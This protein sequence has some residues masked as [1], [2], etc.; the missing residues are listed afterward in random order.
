VNHIDS[1]KKRSATELFSLAER[2]TAQGKPQKAEKIYRKVIALQLDLA[3]AHNNLGD[4]LLTSNRLLEAKLHFSR[5]I[6]LK[7]SI[8][9]FHNNLAN[10]LAA[11]GQYHDAIAAYRTALS[12]QPLADAHNGLGCALGHVGEIQE[13]QTHFSKALEIDPFYVAARMNLGLSL[14]GQGKVAEALE[15][16]VTLTHATSAPGFPV[17]LFGILLARVGCPEG[18]KECFEQYL[19]K[20]PGDKDG[21]A[22]LLAAVGGALPDRVSDQQIGQIY[23]NRAEHWDQGTAGP[24][25]YQGHKL[26]ALTMQALTSQATALDI[27]DA[28]CGTGLVG[29]LLREKARR[30]VGIDL[31]APMLEKARDKKTY[32]ELHRR[33]LVDYLANNPESC[34]VITS[35]ATLIHFG[36]LGPV[37]DAAARCLRAEGFFI[38]T[39][40][41][42]DDADGVAAGTLDGFAQ[43]GCFRHGRNYVARTAEQYGFQVES[44]RA[45]AHEYVRKQ[46]VTG[47]VVALRLTHRVNQTAGQRQPGGLAA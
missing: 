45:E 47:L 43:G 8:G 39:L 34:D 7:P 30:L 22:L 41:P 29:V 2:H 13:A 27:V 3:E 46:P 21:V 38:F 19:A 14:V 37:L 20:N 33:D 15:H 18:A 23:L 1:G 31:S 24:T 12:F 4:I 42:N 40:F 5:A 36:D 6:A 10:V 17:K 35:A 25:G 28:G 44:I 11:E 16:A 26:V 32:D 9:A